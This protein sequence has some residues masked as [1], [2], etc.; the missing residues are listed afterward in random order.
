MSLTLS[1]DRLSHEQP[2]R[3]ELVHGL[4]DG[5]RNSYLSSNSMYYSMIAEILVPFNKIFTFGL[6]LSKM[7]YHNIPL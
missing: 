3:V 1:I 7:F 2:V 6:T 4:E 5:T